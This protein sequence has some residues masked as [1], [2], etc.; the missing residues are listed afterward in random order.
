MI[1]VLKRRENK[2]TYTRKQEA[3][4]RQWQRWSYAAMKQDSPEA[5]KGKKKKKNKKK[6]LP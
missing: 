2:L 4:G 1:S 6:I 3:V 5:R